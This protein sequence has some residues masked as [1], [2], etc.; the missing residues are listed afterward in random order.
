LGIH[1]RVPAENRSLLGIY[2]YW[3]RKCP[4]RWHR[5]RFSGEFV[6]HRWTRLTDRRPAADVVR[7]K[8]E[9]DHL[10]AVL[11]AVRRGRH[12]EYSVGRQYDGG[13]LDPGS[14]KVTDHG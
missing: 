10:L 5:M 14:W 1:R 4:A 12:V 3:C 13:P 7:L 11:D 8:A 6:G 9:R 2:E